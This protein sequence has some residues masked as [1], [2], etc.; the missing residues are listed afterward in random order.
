[1][2]ALP[3]RNV[4]DRN[5]KL[6]V[7]TQVQSLS[8]R[9]SVAQPE[10]LA[11]NTVCDRFDAAFGNT[12]LSGSLR[13]ALCD[14]DYLLSMPNRPIAKPSSEG[15]ARPL[16]DCSSQ[17]DADRAIEPAAEEDGRE[18][19]RI[20][21]MRIDQ[22]EVETRAQSPDISGGRKEQEN[23]PERRQQFRDVPKSRPPDGKDR[24]D[25]GLV[26]ASSTWPEPRD[27]RDD[28]DV[29]HRRQGVGCV[30]RQRCRVTAA[31][32]LEKPR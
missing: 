22:I 11:V 2:K 13:E 31:G 10:A 26:N 6:P 25:R 27:R 19:V 29:G 1:M 17:R 7:L 32:D 8:C 30:Q 12:T 21:K 3:R 4:T 5:Q 15:P 28:V 24:R 18:T 14:G 20:R 23:C 16:D 9:G